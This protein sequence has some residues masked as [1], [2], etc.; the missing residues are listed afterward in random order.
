MILY[1]IIHTYIFTHILYSPYNERI[2]KELRLNLIFSITW[3]SNDDLP[4]MHYCDS[5]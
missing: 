1:I 3:E 4:I 2:D 5:V